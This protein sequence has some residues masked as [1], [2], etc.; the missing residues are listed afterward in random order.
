MI[1]QLCW[2][3]LL[4][5]F[6]DR[7]AKALGQVGVSLSPVVDPLNERAGSLLIFRVT[8][9]AS[10]QRPGFVETEVM[11]LD[12]MAD[13]ERGVMWILNQL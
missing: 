5:L 7:L 4:V 3:S 1:H 9:Q 10:G 8:F 6:H 2:I 11:K 12:S 13:V